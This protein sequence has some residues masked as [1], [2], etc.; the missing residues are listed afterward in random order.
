MKKIKW[1]EGMSN[2]DW[3]M[4]LY[5]FKWAHFWV[6]PAWLFTFQWVLV[7]CQIV[8]EIIRGIRKGI[9]KH[10]KQEGLL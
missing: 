10:L 9:R 4:L 8:Y 2:A 5:I 6:A 1:F 7:I 3:L